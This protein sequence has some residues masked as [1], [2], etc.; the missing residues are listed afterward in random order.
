MKIEKEWIFEYRLIVIRDI[1]GNMEMIS[2]WVGKLE[3]LDSVYW[4]IWFDYH[5]NEEA[6]F[7]LEWPEVDRYIKS[8]T[9]R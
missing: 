7:K 9:V 8:A 3:V 5:C 6:S 2:I 1:L 4:A